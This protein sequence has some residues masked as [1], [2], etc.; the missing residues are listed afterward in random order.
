MVVPI[1]RWCKN[2]ISSLHGNSFTMNSCETS[3][4]FDDEPH[5]KRYMA[6]GWRSLIGHNKLQPSIDRVS[7]VWCFCYRISTE[8]DKTGRKPLYLLRD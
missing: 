1:P 2:D 4:A 5:S 7:G 8:C 3:L 6:V